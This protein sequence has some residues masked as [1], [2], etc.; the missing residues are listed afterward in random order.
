MDGQ[1]ELPSSNRPKLS[2][3]TLKYVV[4]GEGEGEGE[5][6]GDSRRGQDEGTRTRQQEKPEIGGA[7]SAKIKGNERETA[8]EREIRGSVKSPSQREKTSDCAKSLN[9]SARHVLIL[10]ALADVH[11]DRNSDA[12]ES[13]RQISAIPQEAVLFSTS[14]VHTQ[15]NLIPLPRRRR[16]FEREAKLKNK[17]LWTRASSNDLITSSQLKPHIQFYSTAPFVLSVGRL[18]SRVTVDSCFRS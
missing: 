13:F 12:N 9:V 8:N 16:S 15:V 1:D 5:D 11:L 2:K 3:V 18:G 17:A 7:K 14:T 10:R 6:E 4:E